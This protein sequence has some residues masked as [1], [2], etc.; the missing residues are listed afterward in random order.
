MFFRNPI[1]RSPHILVLECGYK[2]MLSRKLREETHMAKIVCFSSCR[3]TCPSEEFLRCLSS[4][5][6]AKVAENC[7]LVETR[8]SAVE[9]RD[10]LRQF[11]C[12]ED[13]LFV[14]ECGPEAAWCNL[15]SSSNRVRDILNSSC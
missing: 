7:W 6:C 8:C 1:V 4:M 5:P 12:P 13:T 15:P 14:A 11:T 3:Q 9:L 10:K 2:N